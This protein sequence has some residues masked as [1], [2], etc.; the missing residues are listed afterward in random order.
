M[1][2]TRLL[3]FRAILLGVFL[4]FG[5]RLAY[6]QLMRGTELRVSSEKNHQRWVRVPAPRGLILDRKGRILATNAPVLTAWLVSGEVRR[7]AWDDLLKRLTDVGIFPNLAAAEE[8]LR[9]YRRYPSYLPVRLRSDMSIRMIT[10]LEEELP[11]MPGVYLQA[12]PMRRYPSGSLAAHLLGFL[13]EVDPD[14]LAIRKN[15]GYHPGDRIGKAGLERAFEENL[16]GM[17][18]RDEVEVDAAGRVLRKLSSRLPQP[19]KTL[20]LTLDLIIQQAAE[21]GLAGHRGAV[22]ALDPSS[23]A[24]LALANA[25]TINPNIMSGRLSPALHRQ[26]RESGAEFC[27]ATAGLYPPGS[28]FKIITATAALEE[29]KLK[30]TDYFYCDGSYKTIHCWKRAGHGALPLTEA[31]AQSCN[32]AFMK[33]AER[34]GINPLAAMARRFGLGEPVGFGL[35][36]ENAGIVPD[37]AWSRRVAHR[38]WEVGDTLQVGIGQASL[39]ITPMQ[40]ARIAAAFAN[41][42]L[43]VH[44]YVVTDDGGVL[45][46]TKPPQPIG[47]QPATIKTVTRGLRAVV[48][49]GTAKQLD[50]SLR[51]SGKTGTAQNPR[52]NDHAWFVGFAP[53]ERPIIAVAVLVEYGGHG[54][55]VA[56]PIAERVIRAALKPE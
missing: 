51:I 34:A 45:Q 6:L 46:E 8:A 32:V 41:G 35:L 20:T 24:I 21:E 12:E 22:I 19:G 31:I 50:P 40:S 56:A 4:I 18:G 44:P 7:K 15:Q 1:F 38:R 13:R 37:P 28:V 2:S 30:P 42:G 11:S 55:A 23:G 52:G 39:Q 17:E 47:L 26:W 9:D 48:G 29:G 10:R 53:A 14:E 5:G 33:I 43:L 27:R 3:L 49:E 36:P 16:R 25:P 54:G